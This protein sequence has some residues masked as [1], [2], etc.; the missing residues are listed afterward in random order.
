MRLALNVEPRYVV[1]MLRREEW[2]IGPGTSPVV[3]ELVWYTD[4]SRTRGGA[5]WTGAGI[6]GQCL[7]RRLSISIR[8]YAIVFQS[9]HTL[10]WPVHVTFMWTLD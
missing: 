9:T 7:A 4:G 5:E 8:K 6:Y 2:T 10:S 3:K 1:T